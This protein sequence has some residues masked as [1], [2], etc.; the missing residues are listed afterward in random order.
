[1]LQKGYTPKLKFEIR[2]FQMESIHSPVTNVV[3]HYPT[4]TYQLYLSKLS[5]K[6]DSNGVPI[7]RG[8]SRIVGWISR[9]S[10]IRDAF[11]QCFM[12][13]ESDL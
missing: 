8:A 2:N 1:M 6:L 9:L 5:F 7:S 12:L 3:K 13:I 4:E 11:V 10:I